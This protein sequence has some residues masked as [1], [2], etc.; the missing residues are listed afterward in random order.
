MMDTNLLTLIYFLYGLAFFSMG[1]AVLIEGDR[2]SDE[3][4]RLSLR[5]LVAFG[6]LHGLHEWLD[7]FENIG[8]VGDSYFS[9][10]LWFAIKLAILAF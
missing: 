10:V 9:H 7:M 5:P 4:L 6:L 1:L 2:S 3:R 8:M